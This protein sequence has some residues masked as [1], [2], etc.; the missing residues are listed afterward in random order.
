MEDR[1]LL[2]CKLGLNQPAFILGVDREREKGNSPLLSID[3]VL[4]LPS[5]CLSESSCYIYVHVSGMQESAQIVS[6]PMYCNCK[7][8][9]ISLIKCV[10]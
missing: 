6:R 4:A 5:P 1:A 3:S 2:L 8:N 7:D 10:P 9:C